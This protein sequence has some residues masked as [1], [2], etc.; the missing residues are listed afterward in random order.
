MRVSFAV[1]QMEVRYGELLA[2][3]GDWRQAHPLLVD[4]AARLQKIVAAV[5]LDGVNRQL[6]DDSVTLLAQAES[7]Q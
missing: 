7:R 6:V 5:S 2:A 4:G 3:R 1:A